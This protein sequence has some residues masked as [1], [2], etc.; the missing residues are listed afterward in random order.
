MGKHSVNM[1]NRRRRARDPGVFTRASLAALLMSG[2][3]AGAARAQGPAHPDEVAASD[4]TGLDEVVVT[5]RKRE[6]RL[7]DVPTAGTALGADAIRA[8]GGVAT[9]Q[10]L[11]TNAPGVNF[12]NT[13]NPVTSEVSIRGSGTSRATNAPAGVGLYRDGA[14]ISG[15]TVGGRTFTDLDLFD[16]ERIEVLRGVQGGLNGRNAEGGAVNV[17]SV[18]PSDH[19]EGYIFASVA[20]L[21]THELQGAVNLPFGE[22]WALRLSGDV[23]R[24]ERG[25]Y[26]LYLLD[27]YADIRQKDFLRGQLRYDNGPFTA[28][29]LVEHGRERLPGL[30]Y[31]A[32]N[33]PSA[34]YPSG[35][36][37]DKYNLPWNSPSEGK[38]QVNNYELTTSYDF[39][40]ADLATTTMVRE[41]RGLNAYDRD[42]S[43]SQFI[44][45]AIAAGLVAPGAV[46]TLRATDYGLGGAQS[47][48]ARIFYQDVHLTGAK[49]GRIEWLAGA[50][51]YLLHDEP[52]NVLGKTPTSA[53]PSPG[54]LDIG[55]SRFSSYAAY[56]SL[57]YDITQQLNLT[58]DLRITRDDEDVDSQR[59]DLRTGASTGV[60][61]TVDGQRKAT[62]A[63]YTVTL[64]YKP[65]AD[66]LIYAKVG[67]AYRA[68]GFNTALGDPRQPIPVP[69]T[70]S[71]ETLTAYELGFKGNLSRDIYLTAAAYQNRFDNLVVQG[72]NGCAVGIPACP[73][74]A[75]SFAFNAGPARLWGLEAEVTGRTE[76]LGGP[77]RVT[78]GG[79][80]QGGHITGG[81]YDG[82]RQPQ[83]PNWTLTFNVNYRHE[84]ADGWTGFA[85]LKGSGRWGGVQEIGQ[86]PPLYDYVILD[87]RLGV[88]KGP[89]EL[90]LFSENLGEESYIVFRSTNANSDVRRFN[91]P[92]TYGV[93]LRYSW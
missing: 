42:A 33:F 80:R 85:N 47:D 32:V 54:T 57:G 86:T 76:V 87:G 59:A 22:H 20:N 81:I 14:Y 92:R 8:L 26:Y 4:A 19:Y 39:G 91:L 65:F 71:N 62:N 89:Y 16:A 72:D 84:L 2:A 55:S 56:G 63:S 74:Q 9:A 24:Q 50:E 38:Q 78:V 11:L 7:R 27:Q 64:G 15:G 6:E 90:A 18:R 82:R 17:V 36:A 83:Q 23:M 46:N 25:F 70:F 48:F 51:W 35:L 12:A 30:I 3:L 28:N 29:L 41:R 44:N 1:I 10:S 93:Q 73:V 52:R 31:Q 13:S 75:T 88:E 58:G 77:L 40:A 53:S 67:S 21:D 79:S 66:T 37:Q 69:L 49:V 60:G 61:F 68:G 43:S 5:A 34:T 45:Q